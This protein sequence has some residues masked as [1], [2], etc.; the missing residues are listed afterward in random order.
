MNYASS[1]LTLALRR[2]DVSNDLLPQLWLR[3]QAVQQRLPDDEKELRE[4]RV[5]GARAILPQQALQ[6]PIMVSLMH[7]LMTLW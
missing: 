3:R 6:V 7:H 2:A 5:R 1:I 4:A